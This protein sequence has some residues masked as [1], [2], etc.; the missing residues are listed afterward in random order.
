[1]EFE[2]VKNIDGEH[3]YIIGCFKDEDENNALI[4]VNYSD[5]SHGLTNKVTINFNKARAITSFGKDG[6]EQEILSGGVYELTLAPGE[7]KFILIHK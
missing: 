4:I 3:P 6:K 2:P 7:G 5:P 1:M